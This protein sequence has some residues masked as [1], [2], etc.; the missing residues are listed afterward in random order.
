MPMPAPIELDV[1]IIGGGPGGLATALAL[2]RAV[3]GTRIKVRSGVQ[4]PFPLSGRCV[5][6]HLS[7]ICIANMLEGRKTAII[8]G[9]SKG[10]S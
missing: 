7:V 2:S 3:K 8:E 1:A 5:S 4:A 10:G 9:Y 6:F